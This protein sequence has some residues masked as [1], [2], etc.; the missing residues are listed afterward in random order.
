MAC[1]MRSL[2]RD[3]VSKIFEFENNDEPVNYLNIDSRETLS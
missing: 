3:I 1:V 2:T